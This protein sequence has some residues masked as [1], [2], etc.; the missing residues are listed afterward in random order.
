[1]PQKHP[2]ATTAVALPL[3]GLLT[4]STAAAGTATEAS[5]P[6]LQAAAIATTTIAIAKTRM[7]INDITTLRS[8]TFLHVI[9]VTTSREVS[10]VELDAADVVLGR[11][12]WLGI[13]APARLPE[14]G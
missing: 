8:S 7:E 14:T 4:S 9:R 5:L 11:T 2:P 12:G 6:A 1:M 3:S 13:S 10:D